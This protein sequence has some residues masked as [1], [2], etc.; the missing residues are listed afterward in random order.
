MSE[1]QRT[2]VLIKPDGV[3]KRLTGTVLARFEKAGLKLVGLKM[4]R[5]TSQRAEDFYQ[6]HR[7]QPFYEPLIVFMTSA[8]I[9]AAVWEGGH[10]VRTAR[11]LMGSTDSAKAEPRSHRNP[12]RQPGFRR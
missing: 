10:A 9:M 4:L 3:C 8:P 1:T 7:G 2:L 5:L 6:E 11:D 12:Y